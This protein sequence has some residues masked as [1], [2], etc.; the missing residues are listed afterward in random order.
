[1]AVTNDKYKKWD[2]N[3]EKWKR[4]REVN[5]ARFVVGD[6]NIDENYINQYSTS[7]SK[8]LS[9]SANNYSNVQWGQSQAALNSYDN[10]ATKLKYQKVLIE[11]WLSKNAKAG[12]YDELLKGFEAIDTGINNLHNVYSN[13]HDTMSKYGSA[14]EYNNA[15]WTHEYGGYAYGDIQKEIAELSSRQNDTEA[16]KKL[17]WLKGFAN[18]KSYNTVAEYDQ[19]IGDIDEQI[20]SLTEQLN[21]AKTK[22]KF[23]SNRS[24]SG[25][26]YTYSKEQQ[27]EIDEL[28][29][30]IARLKA[31]R[32]NADQSKP[33]AEFTQLPATMR[34]D[35]YISAVE[36][37]KRTTNATLEELLGWETKQE[38]LRS[39]AK[40]SA[41][42]GQEWLQ[43]LDNKP[44]ITDPLGFYLNN[45]DALQ[46]HPGSTGVAQQFYDFYQKANEQKWDYITKDEKD[47]Y[48]AVLYLEG[49]DKALE[50]LDRM[51]GT[52]IA[53]KDAE[54]QGKL[55]NFFD[56]NGAL[57]YIGFNAL[58]IPLKSIGGVMA[59]VDNGADYIT[60]KEV[61]PYSELNTLRRGANLIRSETTKDIEENSDFELMGQNVLSQAYNIG[62]SMGESMAGAKLM[63]PAYAFVAG[64]SAAAD[65]AEDIYDRGGTA[66]QVFWGSFAAGAAEMIFEKLSIDKL[67]G[68]AKSAKSAKDIIK[69]SLVQG[70]VEAS[71]EVV[72]E[73]SNKITDAVIMQDKSE[74]NT[75]VN[76]LLKANP[77]MSLE[78]AQ[79]KCLSENIYDVV[80]AGIGGFLSGETGAAVFG[81]ANLSSVNQTNKYI[82]SELKKDSDATNGLFTY[83]Q[84]ISDNSTIRSLLKNNTA[85]NISDKNLGRMYNEV[86]EDIES[87]F[88][89][90]QNND[91][92]INTY[93]D[94]VNNTQSRRIKS[95]AAEYAE[96]QTRKFSKLGEADLSYI[97]SE[98]ETDNAG[99]TAS[100][101]FVGESSG[102]EYTAQEA[103]VL[104]EIPSDILQ[105][106]FGY[107]QESRGNVPA[108][109]VGIDTGSELYKK[110]ASV[111]IAD[112]DGNISGATIIDEVRRRAAAQQ[113][114][115][116]AAE[117]AT[118]DNASA[119]GVTDDGTAEGVDADI[120][121]T[122]AEVVDSFDITDINDYVHV[123]KQV[124]STLKS[125]GFFTDEG[126]T[127]TT[128][129]NGDSGTV[130]EVNV[131]GIKETFYK[132][133]Y[134]RSS[135]RL[136]IAKLATI[137]EIPALIEKGTLTSDNVENAHNADSGVSYAYIESKVNINGEP[138]TVRIAIRKS[139]QKNKFWVHMIDINNVGESVPAGV[140]EG[141][142]T[143]YQASTDGTSVP[144]DGQNVKENTEETEQGGFTDVPDR[145]IQREMTDEDNTRAMLG[146][147]RNPKQR[148][149]EKVAELF[150]V[151]VRWDDSVSEA[152]YNFDTRHIFMNPKLTLSEMYAVVFKHELTH[153]FELKK[154][155]DGFK[156]YLFKSSE[157]FANY[158][159][160]K[161]S[162]VN[163]TVFEGSYEEAI[164]AYTKYKYEQYKNSSEIPEGVRKRFTM[165]MAEMEIVADF[166]GEQLLFGKDADASMNALEELALT[167]RNLF[168]RIWDWVKDVLAKFKK[169]G[170]V[171][172][173]SITKDLE[174]L[175]KR[176]SRVWDS[177]DKKNSTGKGGVKYSLNT[178]S[179]HQK[180]NWATSKRII[181]YENDTQY[182]E[183]IEDSLS[184][185]IADKKIYFGAVSAELADAI[186][187]STGIDVENY[188]CS[189][190][191]DEILKINKDHGNQAKEELRGQRAITVDDYL[192][193]PQVIQS[194]DDIVLSSKL[195][196]GKPVIS[197]IQNGSEKITVSAV[198]SDKRMDLFVQT[199]FIN[200]KKG[201]LATPT[202]EQATVNTPEASSGTVSGTIISDSDENVKHS[203]GLARDSEADVSERAEKMVKSF[204]EYRT[205]T[206]GLESDI[207]TM[208]EYA[209]R[210]EW[211]DA[212]AI[213]EQ[214]SEGF[215][216]KNGKEV[217][218]D[219]AMRYVYNGVLM[220]KVTEQVEQRYEERLNRQRERTREKGREQQS[221]K[222]E[223]EALQDK[224][225]RRD[226]KIQKLEKDI[227][228]DVHSYHEKMEKKRLDREDR[229]KNLNHFRDT[230]ARLKN[231]LDGN[232]D[233]KHIPEHLKE[234]VS[235][236]LNTFKTGEIDDVGVFQRSRI[237]PE[238]IS[239]LMS[240]Y[241]ECEVN[242]R[243]GEPNM[244]YDED[245][246]EFLKSLQEFAENSEQGS[247]T[248]RDLDNFQVMGMM[249]VAGNIW[250]TV[251][252]AEESFQNGR[253]VEFKEIADPC[254]KDLKSHKNKKGARNR[255]LAWVRNLK[256]GNVTPPYFFKHLGEGFYKLYNDVVDGQGKWAK[257][258]SA[259]KEFVYDI[260]KKYNYSKWQDKTV[261]LHTE[262]GKD[263]KLTIE[264][265][266]Q[267]YATVKRQLGNKAQDA[268]HLNIGGIV[269]E[270]ATSTTQWDKI[271]SDLKGIADSENLNDKAKAS[272][273]KKVW[274]AFYEE[275][276]NKAI[277]LTYNDLMQVSEL[278]SDEQK[279]YTDAWVGYLSNNM[280]ALGNETSLQLFGYEKFTENYY[281]PY[282]SAE[283]YLYSQPGAPQ[284]DERIKHL[285]FTKSTQKKAATPLVLS[286]LSEVCASHVDKMCMYN[287]MAIPL[288][289]MNKVF[290]CTL[291]DE[292]GTPTE[293]IKDELNRT[294]G[295][296]AGKY[297]KQFI[298]DAN[299]S[300]RG[301]GE[302]SLADVWISRYKKGAVLA[303]MSVVVQQPTAMMRA[304]AYINPKYFVHL[305]DVKGIGKNYEQLCKYAPVAL[306][307]QMGRFDT[308]VGV[309]NTNWLLEE[310]Y[311]GFGANLKAFFVDSQYRD[312]KLSYLASK[313]DEVTWAHIWTAVK[314]EA[315]A[316]TDLKVGSEEFLQYCGKRF[317][318][319]INLTQVYD[320]TL[321]KSQHMREK[322]GY[323]KML[324]SFMAEPTVTYNILAD[325]LYRAKNEGKAGWKFA[326]RAGTAVLASIV[327]NVLLKSLVY[328]AR[329]DDED[330]TYFEK[331]VKE[332]GESFLQEINPLNLV[333]FVK[334]A[335]ALWQGYDVE[336]ADMSLIGDLF[337]SIKMLESDKKTTGE[338]IESLAGSIA[339]LFGLPVK[340]VVRDIKSTVNWVSEIFDDD[341]NTATGLK[342]A[343]VEGITGEDST[344]SYYDKLAEAAEDGDEETFMEVYSYL[345]DNKKEDSEIIS[346]A[347]AALKKSDDV[348][349]EA[350]DYV[351]RLKGNSSYNALDD[352]DK[353]SFAS[354]VKEAL[355]VEIL[356]DMI[357]GSDK[358]Y[359]KLYEAQRTDSKKYKELKKKLT[360]KGVS[361]SEINI[362]LFAAE[363]RYIESLGIDIHEW[364]LA[365]LAKGKKYADTDESGG[366]SKAE[367]Q[368]AVKDLDVSKKTKQSLWSYYGLD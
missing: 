221:L 258:F 88:E 106:A 98:S 69:N 341:E 185:K 39:A 44:V 275:Y 367:K 60:G 158:V 124:I 100:G 207:T 339:N 273:V 345:I 181:L 259:T 147:Y 57:A 266:M 216:G 1:M 118:P 353:K 182:R 51:K 47:L 29:T 184:G 145:E 267:L 201:N 50:Y 283:N 108:V 260:K 279:G 192:K 349:S 284:G 45:P 286:S 314:A 203:I 321:T 162:E 217:D 48:Y 142:I 357:S 92:V 362:K 198:V 287:A 291:Y 219:A 53:R 261:V 17:D 303:S 46:Q 111:G 65:A 179:Q 304:M 307:K 233:A 94:I 132:K 251:K 337:S 11:D 187:R 135:K 280:A 230:Y 22:G 130:V 354:K 180:D 365:E 2:E 166:V 249:N 56:E 80:W 120:Q 95:I 72:T 133:N 77:N 91:D 191:S 269:L 82:G 272:K 32:D 351:K 190:S 326:G 128:V 315:K 167:D 26:Y 223:N 336:R 155:Y 227:E 312:D 262:R 175:E 107:A 18:T 7:A 20:K 228:Q 301:S 112:S 172:D 10:E 342:Y 278:L 205:G 160:N 99:D 335:L 222:K 218:T 101:G 12:S 229:Q 84:G 322:T 176:L 340:N 86:V 168:Q 328:A 316:E 288:E 296:E 157:A 153:D 5:K 119:E 238:L 210:S 235:S 74:F 170:D 104:A 37:G 323:K 189:L 70:G 224:L 268:Q 359:D 350:N 366:V 329:D 254:L 78:E 255:A 66:D 169:R 161:L 277:Q 136:K 87:R 149:V 199:A 93:N 33:L 368:Q 6:V 171:Q 271:K 83:A 195:Y 305:K 363:L 289:N 163:D 319:V 173:T 290:N 309:S 356:D 242:K 113:A 36:E 211:T 105:T 139:T 174:Y 346:G 141:S 297:L 252:L 137:R 81:S 256:A 89:N 355:S 41:E 43:L 152:Y 85:E 164:E 19:V 327:A 348:V 71:E 343:L 156:N 206:Q 220:K 38:E 214:I 338:K 247:I 159:M 231:R 148:Q 122:D 331:Y 300:V 64:S 15:L 253:S 109:N 134:G 232:T 150:G 103:A 250:Q 116:D 35:A 225:E 90:T 212:H 3:Y 265:A 334:D 306:I 330:K 188:N 129:T 208:L 49:T 347:K 352:D 243:T 294:F 202:A 8:F 96:K 62:M 25:G 226:K 54:D 320:S 234:L 263:I 131:K 324:T 270:D 58:S 165:E 241:K 333:P 68:N 117:R 310:G 364:A 40:T 197:F 213:A 114:K 298:A 126:G 332:L 302:D 204:G 73:L 186:K 42:A 4:Q 264:Q 97:Q 52:F 121:Y 61:N 209:E 358:E 325:A 63:G 123:Q 193:L 144:Q 236:F 282:N 34:Q 194:A 276:D 28:E 9:D 344:S 75:R 257:N 115:Y 318:E 313:A 317:T 14:D 140:S 27:T 295:P 125:E 274:D 239:Y 151:K 79:L 361:E 183:F 200:T 285:S 143:G 215:M 31:Y 127:S 154:N 30:E 311:E 178:Y 299:G 138:A 245:I 21:K 244:A 67:L 23:H 76:E 102:V 281:I 55:D 308:G 177:K 24:Q 16:Q 292:N 293:N 13:L 246:Y 59:A 146:D 196:N 360:D 240:K 248:T 110:L 237:T